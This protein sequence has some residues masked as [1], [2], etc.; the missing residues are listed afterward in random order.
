MPKIKEDGHSDSISDKY[1]SSMGSSKKI[2][3]FM[4]DGGGTP[5]SFLL[6]K[7]ELIRKSEP[8]KDS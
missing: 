8:L 5:N 7:P 4:E 3:N 1:T 6:K 2:I